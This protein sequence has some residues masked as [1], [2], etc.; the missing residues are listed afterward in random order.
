MT[1]AAKPSITSRFLGLNSRR[2]NT[3]AEPR[4][5]T[6]HVN[7]PAS[8]AWATGFQD[9]MEVRKDMG[10]CA[11]VSAGQGHAPST[12]NRDTREAANYPHAGVEGYFGKSSD[13]VKLKPQSG[14]PVAFP[15]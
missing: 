3:S 8:V 14:P 10:A 2:A 13:T 15:A 12:P 6:A 1:P 9:S 11:H 4:A 5:V 7:T